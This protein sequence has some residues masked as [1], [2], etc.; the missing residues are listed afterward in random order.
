MNKCVSEWMNEQTQVNN[1]PE[2]FLYV[3]VTQIK[4]DSIY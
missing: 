1:M 4:V 2:L 3:S